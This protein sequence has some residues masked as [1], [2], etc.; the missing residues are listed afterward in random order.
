MG[1]SLTKTRDSSKELNPPQYEAV[2]CLNGPILVLAGAG[3][4]KTRVI[5]YR[6]AHL[7]DLGVLPY[8]ILAVTFTN[9]AAEEMKNRVIDL[10]GVKAKTM[11]IA[12]FHATCVRILREYGDIKNFTIYDDNDQQKLIKECLEEFDINEKQFKP[13]KIL[14]SISRAKENLIKPEGFL[15]NSIFNRIVKDIYVKYQEKL[16]ENKAFDFDDLISEVIYLFHRREDILDRLQDRFKHILVDEYQDIN[17][18]QYELIRLL[19]KKHQSICVV[20]DDDQCIYQWRGANI[21]HILNFE[22]DYPLVKTV[23]LEENYRST[24]SILEAANKVV[25]H[26][27]QR[28][29]KTLWANRGKGEPIEIFEASNEYEEAEYVASKILE[30]KHKEGRSAHEFLVLYRVNAQSRI[31]ENVFRKYDLPYTIVGGLS[32]YQR[33]EIKDL[34][35]YLRILINLDDRISIE[36]IINV[37]SRGIGKTSLSKVRAYAISKGISF[38]E[39][40]SKVEEIGSAGNKI[41]NSI[42]SFTSLLR[43]LIAKKEEL[44]L[45]DLV[46]EVII[47]SGYISYLKQEYTEE[48]TMQRIENLEEFLSLIKE[49]EESSEDRSLS[50]FLSQAQLTADIDNWKDVES[51]VNL[52]TLHNAKGLE[53][54]VVFLVGVEEGIFPHLN[55]LIEERIEEERRL[56]YVGIT[57]AKDRLFLTYTK[58]RTWHGVTRE[59]APSCFLEELGIKEKG[60]DESSFDLGD[61]NFIGKVVRHRRWGEGEITNQK[62]SGDNL[63]LT[64]NFISGETR[65]LM[66]KYAKLEIVE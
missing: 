17:F 54:P 60:K 47:K 25:R 51:K 11:W 6:I 46:R 22:E 32:F 45:M 23:K 61:D 2:T 15:A 1:C 13:S 63:Q 48:D 19:A 42:I 52:M 66:N 34:V 29:E 49:F 27:K 21:Y 39:A 18:A 41:K 16:L 31:F 44:T 64:V 9:K 14:A 3:S 59:S 5:T 38:F 24:S 7:T 56:C 53:F 36:R 4:G 37:P 43:Y 65:V 20:G 40:L 26:N 33:K 55:A 30:F 62:G 35:A 50:S 10:V 28:K 57:R 12:T 58:Y 8:Q